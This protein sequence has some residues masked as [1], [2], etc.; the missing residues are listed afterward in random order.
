MKINCP[1][2]QARTFAKLV[3]DDKYRPVNVHFIAQISHF[4]VEH[5]KLLHFDKIEGKTLAFIA[6]YIVLLMKN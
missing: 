3:W 2:S 6:N 1:N 4:R 5:F